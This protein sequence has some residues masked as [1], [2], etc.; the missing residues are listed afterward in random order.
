[1][2]FIIIEI[3]LEINSR[4]SET[5][6]HAASVAN[7][8]RSEE[9]SFKFCPPMLT[10]LATPMKWVF[11]SISPKYGSEILKLKPIY[12]K[13]TLPTR[14]DHARDKYCPRFD[15]VIELCFSATGRD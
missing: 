7:S 11:Y 15:A 13:I 3:L 12:I 8:E 5:A 6:W 10:R 4:D 9:K 1:M 2:E 14:Q